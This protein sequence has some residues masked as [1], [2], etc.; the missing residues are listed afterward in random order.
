[1]PTVLLV[2]HAHTAANAAGILAGVGTDGG[3]DDVGLSQARALAARLAAVP[4]AA[5][6]SGP[7]RRCRETADILMADHAGPSIIVDDRLTECDYGAWTGRP[8]R[9][10]S[11]ERLWRVVQTHP[12]AVTF[13]G[14]ESMR[15]VQARAVDAVRD[16]DARVAEAAGPEAVW[17]AVSHSDVIKSVVAD[18]LGM[19]L[20]QFQR[21]VI[22]PGS[23]TALRYT[24]LRPF[25]VCLNDT[26]GD[27]SDLRRRGRRR[28]AN[29]RDAI[30]GGGTG[31]S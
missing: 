4:L 22:D 7:L 16:H 23:L 25:A 2:R 21:L 1:V 31:T 6:V 14:G 27:L 18:T 26:G 11:R 19:H 15:A 13:P 3:L 9:E 28:R 30:V 17:L 20:D 29:P 12:S 5:V 24:D 8:L 10:L